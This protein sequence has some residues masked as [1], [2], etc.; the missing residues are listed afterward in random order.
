[1]K[2]RQSRIRVKEV[3]ELCKVLRLEIS[4]RYTDTCLTGHTRSP[5]PRA[6]SQQCAGKLQG[7]L[8]VTLQ[9]AVAGTV[10][11]ILFL[12]FLFIIQ[13]LLS[14]RYCSGCYRYAP[15]SVFIH[16]ES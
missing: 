8:E 6:G 11:L 4:L 3:R 2:H 15:T 5:L 10:V 12:H 9:A 7:K 13:H 16:L 1:M 14:V